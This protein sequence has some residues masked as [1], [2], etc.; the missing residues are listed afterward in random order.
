MRRFAVVA[1]LVL[2]VLRGVL[3]GA[4]AQVAVQDGT[5]LEF[6]VDLEAS[7]VETR[8]VHSDEWRRYAQYIPVIGFLFSLGP[9]TEV[10]EHSKNV[11]GTFL[12]QGASGQLKVVEVRRGGVEFRPAEA[13]LSVRGSTLVLVFHA[14]ES[15]GYRVSAVPDRSTGVF[16]GVEAGGYLRVV[17][18][19]ERYSIVRGELVVGWP[20][21]EAAQEALTAAGWEPEAAREATVRARVS[22]VPFPAADPEN[23]PSRTL[24][25]WVRSEAGQG[26]VDVSVAVL[27]GTD[28]MPV[29]EGG[30]RAREVRLRV[31]VAG[32]SGSAVLHDGPVQ[33]GGQVTVSAR[34][35][36][37][38]V[39][40]VLAGTRT[41][42]QVPVQ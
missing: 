7:L 24:I 13:R 14:P 6:R 41:L 29:L 35:E 8:K 38:A 21:R 32:A 2:L 40:M 33:V 3:P 17:G 11:S 34:V 28:A 39:L 18:L 12:E 9:V 27:V 37:P 16:R 10:F 15:R 25:R 20:S 1:A 42:A 4:S 31:V 5:G 30:Q 23:P 22:V 19:Q 36:T 26:R